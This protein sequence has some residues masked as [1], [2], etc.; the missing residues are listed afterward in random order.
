MSKVPH[1]TSAQQF[2]NNRGTF[3]FWQVLKNE[4]NTTLFY[5][6]SNK[7]KSV[8]DT[9]YSPWNTSHSVH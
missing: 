2:E 9:I 1:D 8:L 3:T 6:N 4:V 5:Y 7:M